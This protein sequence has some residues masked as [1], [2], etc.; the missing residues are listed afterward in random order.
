MQIEIIS[1]IGI[2]AGV[3]VFIFMATKGFQ[4]VVTACAASL[5]II[6]TSGQPIMEMINVT[7]TGGFANFLKSYFLVLTLSAVI[8]KLMNDSGAAKRIARSL[9]GV[10]KRG[11]GNQKLIAA[12][13]VP[14]MYI[15]LCYAG[16]SGLV[17]VFTVLGIGEQI[18]REFDIPWRLYCY[19]GAVSIVTQW[20]PGSL[21]LVNIAAGT[22][23]GTPISGNVGL[24]LVAT[25]VY[26]CV[27]FLFLASDLKQAEKKG[28]GF[29][30][31][32]AA[33]AATVKAPANGQG[34]KLPSMF[35]S[36]LPLLVT[37]VLAIAFQIHIV[38]ALFVG[39]VLEMLCF[40][41]YL[42]GLK[43]SLGDGVISAFGPVVGVGATAAVATVITASPGFS[44]VVGV[45]SN[46]PAQFEG[47]GYIAL[48]TFI[49]ATG[50]GS[51]SSMGAKAL[52]CFT[53]AGLSPLTA[54]KLM[55]VATFTTCPP[56][57]SAVA[58][59][60]VVAKLEY[61]R[62]IGIYLKVT[63][64][65]G[66]CAMAACMLLVHLGIFI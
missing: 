53:N 17:V 37:L 14:I 26:L 10:C 18:M 5:I 60:T 2:L 61:K 50:A 47:I 48:L 3:G 30:E 4:L 42:P 11:R 62:I 43:K 49:M 9:Y 13:F 27:T 31:T 55:Q 54:S 6:L 40:S 7:W 57:S 41:K 21:N 44:L 38:A 23:T 46:L 8:G 19:G 15:I 24:G 22:T 20:M 1:L 33:F 25:V 39:V 64:V 45:L 65:G 66:A 29:M 36:V 35:I 16:I 63:F 51:I 58:N 12:L 56:H 59:V 34:E 52:E 32:G 28:E